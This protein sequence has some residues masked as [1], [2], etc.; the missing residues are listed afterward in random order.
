MVNDVTAVMGLST[1]FCFIADTHFIPGFKGTI[2][3]VHQLEY[4]GKTINRFD[5]AGPP[6]L[7]LVRIY[8]LGRVA[9]D[10]T[11]H[12]AQALLYFHY[13]PVLC[14]SKGTYAKQSVHRML[15]HDLLHSLI[16]VPY[17]SYCYF[18]SAIQ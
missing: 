13:T 8:F 7:S 15:K 2:L 9:K 12:F 17:L 4:K 16:L 5:N 18:I 10:D 1:Y 6:W 3:C 11:T 14:L